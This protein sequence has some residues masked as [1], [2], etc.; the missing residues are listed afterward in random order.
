MFINFLIIFK[1][2]PCCDRGNV[3]PCVGLPE[4]EEL[5]GLVLGEELEPLDEEVVKVVSNLL[6]EAKK[7][8]DHQFPHVFIFK[9][10]HNV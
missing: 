3:L 7:P 9:Q 10:E 8:L 1:N 6:L 4:G 5:I 2:S